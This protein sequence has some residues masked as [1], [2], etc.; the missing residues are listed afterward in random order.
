M[1]ATLE[2]DDNSVDNDVDIE[3]G[4]HPTEPC[5]VIRDIVELDP[6]V[7]P[8]LMMAASIAVAESYDDAEKSE[9]NGSAPSNQ[10]ISHNHYIMPARPS[11]II[12]GIVELHPPVAPSMM[13]AASL[14]VR[15]IDYEEKISAP[16]RNSEVRIRGDFDDSYNIE[17]S[18][19]SANTVSS[20]SQGLMERETGMLESFMSASENSLSESQQQAADLSVSV[21]SRP[22]HTSLSESPGS[23]SA[24]VRR[25][26][27]FDDDTNVPGRAR[28]HEVEATLVS[29][30]VHE[31]T[32]VP[33]AI[34]DPAEDES[35]KS[36]SEAIVGPFP[37]WRHSKKCAIIVLVC[38]IGVSVAILGTFLAMKGNEG[39]QGNVTDIKRGGVSGSGS[40]GATVTPTPTPPKLPPILPNKTTPSA[41]LSPLIW[42][43]GAVV[44][45]KNDTKLGYS[46]S[47][48]ASGKTVATS[49]PWADRSGEV[50]VGQVRVYNWESGP[51]LLFKSTKGPYANDYLGLSVDLSADGMT[52]AV[53]KSGS[54]S[55]SFDGSVS[56]YD[57]NV[58]GPW[59][60]QLG[61]SMVGEVA[62]D[63]F[64]RSISLSGDGKLLA[65]GS[66]VVS[67]YCI[68]GDGSS[69]GLR[70]QAL[71]IAEASVSLSAF[72]EVLAIG[73]WKSGHVVVY[74]WDE[75]ASDYKQL[76]ETISAGIDEH[77]GFMLDL[78]AD[79][80]TL[81][82]GAPHND[83]N[84]SQSGQVKV[85]IWNESSMNFNQL[86]QDIN[87]RS[88]G[89]MLGQSI[90]ISSDGKILA[91]GAPGTSGN[92]VT[93]GHVMMYHIENERSGLS[94]AG[95]LN[96]EA[97]GDLFGYSISLSADGMAL[98]VGAPFNSN[99]GVG[100]VSLFK[101]K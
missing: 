101:V 10:G 7:A 91:I 6:P 71:N 58:D 4:L 9:N 11:E 66:G 54:S 31:A 55:P 51:K 63:S 50:N 25:A 32:L 88:G 73:D 37:W 20:S 38:I 33:D 12:R 22:S 93:R 8:V 46:V 15:D 59:W 97:L 82:I 39:I 16:Q 77:F 95:E 100:K 17:S 35:V 74:G 14:Q 83:S 44:K 1:S 13:M 85:F 65:I 56:I 18:L 52:M 98:V 29:D 94:K 87:G 34:P 43:Q 23:L 53:G 62:G 60:Q 3:E 19:K 70:G 79:G 42:T 57:L 99:V 64:R 24:A 72:G 78:S 67:V 28:F 96:G 40:N 5:E 80:K 47:L 84:G 61:K 30:T 48:S 90:S 75:A 68:E 76:G 92:M 69:W 21:H 81:V 27:T 89:E 26:Q 2:Q 86:G 41:S 49:A 45:A 36:E